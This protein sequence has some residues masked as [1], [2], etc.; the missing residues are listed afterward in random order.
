[1]NSDLLRQR[2]NLIAISTV[3]LIFDFA[4]VEVAKV[5]VLGTE[6]LV[7]NTRMLMV[8]AWVLWGY[9]LLRYYQYWRIENQRRIRKAFKERL[10]WHAREYTKAR[11]VQD[12]AGQLFDDYRITRAGLMQWSHTLRGYDP[13]R[14]MV[15]GK[16]LHLPVPRLVVWSLKSAAHVTIQTPYATDHILPFALA[17]AAPLVALC[18]YYVR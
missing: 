16:P 10:D 6:L 3:L 2:R 1:M 11:P 17:I 13:S 18:S 15:G 5:S 9:F 14:G 12:A 7:G 8:C 4:H